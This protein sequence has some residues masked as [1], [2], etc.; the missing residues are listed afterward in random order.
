[1]QRLDMQQGTLR[2]ESDY[3]FL[4]DGLFLAAID[5]DGSHGRFHV[6][7]GARLGGSLRVQRDAGPYVDGTTYEVLR[8]DGG[9][10]AGTTFDRIE[11]PAPTRLVGFSTQQLA[12]AFNVRADVLSFTTVAGA[13]NAQRVAGHLDRVLPTARGDLR[14]AL[15][16]IQN[17]ASDA[18]FGTAFASLSPAMYEQG[19][20]AGMTS[21]TQFVQ[22]VEQRTGALQV[23][24]RADAA[25]LAEQPIR[26]ASSGGARQVLEAAEQR[27]AQP[28]GVW[29]QAFAQRGDQD[30]GAEF[31]G[32]GFDLAGFA[33]GVDH[34]FGNA[35]S[36]GLSFGRVQN[37][38][39]SDLA[40][41]SADVDSN[42]LA[43]YGSYAR[44]NAYVDGTLSAGNVRYD[45]RRTIVVASTTTPVASKHDAK[46]LALGL[47]A[48]VLVRAGEHWLDPFV[49][50]R[51]TRLKEDAF[52]ESGSGIGLA[53][54]ARPT[55][56]LVSELG[57]RWTRVYGASGNAS[58]A[59]EASVAWLH[60][61]GRDDRLINAAYLDAPDASFAIEGQPVERNGARASLGVTYRSNSGFVSFL[62]YTAELRSGYRAQAVIGEIRYE[63]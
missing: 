37:T 59:P 58:F 48:G 12:D 9:F 7:G 15:R 50:L 18:E 22:T 57:V 23:G 34:R 51:Y 49:R 1:M 11:L 28:Y 8:A 10:A 17:M 41:N 38:V 21:A 3:R 56:A 6:I 63:F 31:S 27:R 32:Y 44:G 54:A 29:M 16:T 36:A 60:D 47:G 40:G 25:R 5:G 2:V 62:R 42:L 39:E 14:Q 19:T 35:F 33:I 61:F 53:V 30:P 13:P 55:D 26:L 4:G 46:V 45:S 20:R 43:L 52:A 24:A